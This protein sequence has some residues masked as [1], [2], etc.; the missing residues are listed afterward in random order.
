MPSSD[1]LTISVIIPVRNG[2]E[3]F[4]RCLS[5]LAEAI[6]APDEIIVVADGDS[7]CSWRAAETL[8]ARVIKLPV[9]GGPGKARN[10]G[11]RVAAGD[12]LLFIDSD[13]VIPPETVGKIAVI[14]RDDLALAA[15]FGSYDD[16]PGAVNFLSQYK[17]L[18][19]HYVHQTA[20][21]DASTFWGGCGAI[22]RKVF[23]ALDGFDE[24]YR[25][26]SIEDIELGYRLR[27]AGYRILLCK[28]LQVK[29]LKRWGALSL[30]KSDFLHRALPWTELTLRHRRLLNDL[31][32]R[33][34]DRVSGVLACALAASLVGAWWKIGLLGL[35]TAL[36][37]LL[38]ALNAPLYLFFHR[39]RGLK[40]TLQAL[41]WHWFYYLYSAVAFAVGAL[42]Y[43]ARNGASRTS[44]LS[45]ANLPTG[46]S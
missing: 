25:H 16:A 40:F 12:V 36:G 26:P 42:L 8:G 38:L 29:H 11:A 45:K 10:H 35:A 30:L 9:S 46:R 31:N 23:L 41:L 37:L 17:N 27:Q 19:H 39:K 44:R 33:L 13:V 2:G 6:P 1:K 3:N 28:G 18:L 21:A 32:L 7:D 14:F 34:S 4:R 24:T 22:R 20:R 5:S 43:L 15:L